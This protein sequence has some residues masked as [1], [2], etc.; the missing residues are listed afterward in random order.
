[1]TD[2]VSFLHF[3]PQEVKVEGDPIHLGTVPKASS[4]LT[5]MALLVLI[6]CPLSLLPQSGPGKRRRAGLGFPGTAC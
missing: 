4:K 6:P 3:A 5:A 1:M 2:V